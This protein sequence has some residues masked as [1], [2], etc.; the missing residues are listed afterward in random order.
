MENMIKAG[1]LGLALSQVWLGKTYLEGSKKD[2]IPQ[3]LPLAFHWLTLAAEQENAE[4]QYHLATCYEKGLGVEADAEKAQAWKEKA[5]AQGFKPPSE[6]PTGD[7][8]AQ[9]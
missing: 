1:E 9:K 8:D 4:A 3:D 6:E 5:L 7:T 2:K